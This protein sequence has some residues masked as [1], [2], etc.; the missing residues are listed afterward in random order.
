[1]LNAWLSATRG[2]P[3]EGKVHIKVYASDFGANEAE[4]SKER[5]VRV[6]GWIGWR[7]GN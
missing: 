1:M 5:L 2:L 6:E 3:G 4:P 7:I